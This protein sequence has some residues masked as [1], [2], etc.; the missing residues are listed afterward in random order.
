MQRLVAVLL[1][2]ASMSSTASAHADSG[3]GLLK[4]PGV[5]ARW[6][7]AISAGL[8]LELAIQ[9]FTPVADAIVG[10]RISRRK[11]TAV[12]LYAGATYASVRNFLVEEAEQARRDEVFE[13]SGV[14]VSPR[15]DVGKTSHFV[16]L[17]LGPGMEVGRGRIHTFG[18]VRVG[19]AIPVGGECMAWTFDDAH[20]AVACR[21]RTQRVS[22]AVHARI[23]AKFSIFHAA[24]HSVL[25]PRRYDVPEFTAGRTTSRELQKTLAIAAATIGVTFDL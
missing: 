14:A 20:S 22:A 7:P 4:E 11:P 9:S 3:D 1:F 15:I 6:A 13:M 2:A 21:D 23:G 19:V 25:M 12:L 5:R 8:G 16:A 17:G 24:V 18:D 10:Y